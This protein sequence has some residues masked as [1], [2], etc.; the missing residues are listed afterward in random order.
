MN[1]SM[2]LRLKIMC[3]VLCVCGQAVK[4]GLLRRGRVQRKR[5][6]R[7]CVEPAAAALQGNSKNEQRPAVRAECTPDQRYQLERSNSGNCVWPAVA[8][9]S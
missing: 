4:Y 5:G 7:C 2:L 9:V 1:T 8:D 6:V 3:V